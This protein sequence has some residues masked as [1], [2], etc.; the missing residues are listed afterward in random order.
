[1]E[2]KKTYDVYLYRYGREPEEIVKGTDRAEADRLITL[3]VKKGFVVMLEC[4]EIRGGDPVK[5][6]GYTEKYCVRE[7]IHTTQRAG[8]AFMAARIFEVDGDG[9]ITPRDDLEGFIY[10]TCWLARHSENKNRPGAQPYMVRRPIEGRNKKPI[11]KTA[12]RKT[13]NI[14]PYLAGLPEYTL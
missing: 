14:D 4:T 3:N 9:I 5:Y 13:D 1:M 8:S 2:K 10:D 6:I 12:V 11:S 7:D